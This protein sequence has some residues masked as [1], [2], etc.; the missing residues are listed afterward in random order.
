M[1]A[2]LYKFRVPLLEWYF[3]ASCCYFIMLGTDGSVWTTALVIGFVNTYVVTP[4][5]FAISDIT[6]EEVDAYYAKTSPTLKNVA[7]SFLL[8]GGILGIYYLI[9][10]YL[11]PTGVDAYS[12]GLLYYLLDKTMGKIIKKWHNYTI[13]SEQSKNTK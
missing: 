6:K 11:F 8:C 4:I 3:V 10:L 2:F 7:K 5:I 12:F 13:I 9:D 1:K